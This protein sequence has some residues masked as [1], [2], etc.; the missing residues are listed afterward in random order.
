MATGKPSAR[1]VLTGSPFVPSSRPLWPQPS[2]FALCLLLFESNIFT[3]AFKCPPNSFSRPLFNRT[4]TPLLDFGA[5]SGVQEPCQVPAK[6]AP[7]QPGVFLSHLR[8]RTEGKSE[9][10]AHSDGLV[11]DSAAQHRAI[12]RLVFPRP[13]HTRTFPVDQPCQQQDSQDTNKTL[14]WSPLVQ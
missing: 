11:G 5:T 13:I 3:A 10:G 8:L 7:S 1:R 14:L 2:P 9:H 4:H 6:T 12:D